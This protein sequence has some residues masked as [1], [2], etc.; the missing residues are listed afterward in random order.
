MQDHKWAR[1]L[2]YVTGLVNQRLLLQCEYHETI[3]I[4]KVIDFYFGGHL[5]LVPGWTGRGWMRSA[6]GRNYYLW[7]RFTPTTPGYRKFPLQGTAFLC[8]PQR[9]KF[10]LNFGGS[11]APKGSRNNRF[12]LE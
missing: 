4:L 7:F 11:I 3:R 5:H 12:T 2:A 6:A 1:L 9:E 8:T 10:R